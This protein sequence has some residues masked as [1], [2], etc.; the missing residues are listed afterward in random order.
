VVCDDAISGDFALSA[1]LLA[2]WDAVGT[3]ILAR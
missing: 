3:V 1:K 2:G